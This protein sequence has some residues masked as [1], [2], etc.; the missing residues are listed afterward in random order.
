MEKHLTMAVG[1]VTHALLS[2]RNGS[3]DHSIPP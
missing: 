1:G 3:T 2:E